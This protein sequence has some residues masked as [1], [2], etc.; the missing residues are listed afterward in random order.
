MTHEIFYLQQQSHETLTLILVGGGVSSA[1]VVAFALYLHWKGRHARKAARL[2]AGRA[3]GGA[4]AKTAWATAPRGQLTARKLRDI[5]RVSTTAADS[6]HVHSA[7][8]AGLP[9]MARA[10]EPRARRVP[11]LDVLIL[12]SCVARLQRRALVRF[13]LA[14]SHAAIAATTVHKTLLVGSA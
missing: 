8:G 3:Q 2:G 11:T 5:A 13:G 14:A 10:S 7:R 9:E 4:T 1:F 12:L 6:L